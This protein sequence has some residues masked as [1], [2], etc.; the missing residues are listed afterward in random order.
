MDWGCLGNLVSL[1]VPATTS[2]GP[3]GD[4]RDWVS[5]SRA[6]EESS[7]TIYDTKEFLCVCPAN[8]E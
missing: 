1:R 2:G 3:C 8:V 6:L 4:T 5:V 7:T